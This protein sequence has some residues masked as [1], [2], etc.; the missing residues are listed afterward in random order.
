MGVVVA[1]GSIASAAGTGVVAG[2]GAGVGA[3]TV[4]V[5]GA[6]VASSATSPALWARSVAARRPQ[7]STPRSSSSTGC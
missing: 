5:A 4:G 6:V 2:A 7:Q 3:A 1:A